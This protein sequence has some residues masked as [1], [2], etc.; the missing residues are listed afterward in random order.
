MDHEKL[1]LPYLP[2]YQ[3]QIIAWRAGSAL[4]ADR[5]LPRLKAAM[6]SI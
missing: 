4:G 2:Y 1:D 6:R 3:L 5:L